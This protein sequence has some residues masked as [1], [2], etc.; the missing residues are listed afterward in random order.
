MSVALLDVNFLVA[1][2]DPNHMNHEEAHQWFA[3]NEKKG[4]ATSSHTENGCVRVL[5][6][7]SY[8]AR[9]LSP[10]D[11]AERLRAFCS[12]SEFHRFWPDALSLRDGTV[13]VLP[14]LTG[15]KRIT[16][17]YLLGVAVRNLGRLVTFDRAIPLE[18]VSGALP[19]NI[20]ILGRV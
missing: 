1:I 5:S 10:M 18:V 16:D 19:R 14:A 3:R 6:S 2:F 11:A 8:P 9:S 12:A 17:A 4:W 20:V 13:F 7:H 15:P